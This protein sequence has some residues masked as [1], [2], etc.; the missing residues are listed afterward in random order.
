MIPPNT[1]RDNC[2]H[3]WKIEPVKSATSPGICQ[4]C[5]KK[6]IFQNHASVDWVRTKDI[7]EDLANR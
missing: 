1:E 4:K 5:G 7:E 2:V 6:K 3:D